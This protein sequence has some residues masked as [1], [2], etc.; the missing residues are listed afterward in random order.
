[1]T[2]SKLYPI[3]KTFNIA[4]HQHYQMPF[5]DRLTDFH[6]IHWW[7]DALDIL[8]VV[9]LVYQLFKFV[10]G[11]AAMRIFIG[12]IVIYSLWK[13]TRYLHMELINEIL[14]Q[15]IGV[16][17][18][19]LIIVFQQE[20]RKFLL[21]IAS[22][23]I[24][25]RFW[26][27][28]WLFKFKKTHSEEA[29]KVFEPVVEACERLSRTMTGALIVITQGSELDAYKAL[30][31]IIDAQIN[32]HLLV[33]IFNKESPLHDGAV[34]ITDNRI[35]S[36]RCVLPVSDR[37]DLPAQLGLRHRAAIGVTENSTAIAIVVSEQNGRISYCSGGRLK[38]NISAKRLRELLKSLPQ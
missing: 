36:A 24:Y 15:F 6:S 25:N 34:F 38:N 4:S 28:K 14:G 13:A 21:L 5:I 9:F 17:V 16:G 19:A 32:D 2:P 29:G 12:A 10:R 26:L 18:I 31:E 30:G 27:T 22:P 23:K 20:I 8:I 33:S 35:A 11:T 37:Q 7:L 1:M 3:T